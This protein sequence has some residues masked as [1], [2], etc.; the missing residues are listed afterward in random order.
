VNHAAWKPRAIVALL[1]KQ[2]QTGNG[3]MR[4]PMK[5]AL[6]AV[7][8]IAGMAVF[9][10]AIVGAQALWGAGALAHSAFWPFGKRES[11]QTPLG[12]DFV[13]ERRP[14]AIAITRREGFLITLQKIGKS[15]SLGLFDAGEQHLIQ[16][17]SVDYDPHAMRFKDLVLFRYPNPGRTGKEDF[18]SDINLDGTI[19][20]KIIRDQTTGKYRVLIRLK[21]EWVPAL[22]QDGGRWIADLPGGRTPVEFVEDAWQIA[23]GA[24]Q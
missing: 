17:L 11:N 22:R 18:F 4:T 12:D 7:A 3:R 13:L 23:G 1:T 24:E 16:V 6:R 5:M 20:W 19:D 9:Y 15:W 14:E 10:L 2:S 8:G 21:G